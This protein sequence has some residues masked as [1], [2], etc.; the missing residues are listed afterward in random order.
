MFDFF[1][2]KKQSAAFSPR[3]EIERLTELSPPSTLIAL[4]TKGVEEPEDMGK[5]F[6]PSKR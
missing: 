3:Q 6:F 1:R 4:V 5:A 2:K